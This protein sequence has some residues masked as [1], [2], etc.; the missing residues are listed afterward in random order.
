MNSS[1]NCAVYW[2][3]ILYVFRI[4]LLVFIIAGFLQTDK[5]KKLEAHSKL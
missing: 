3:C 4:Q 5:N 1:G 2:Y